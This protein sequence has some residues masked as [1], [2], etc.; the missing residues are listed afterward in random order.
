MLKL[1]AS[2]T[3]P[4]LL[5]SQFT[6]KLHSTPLVGGRMLQETGHGSGGDFTPE[7]NPRTPTLCNQGVRII[8]RGGAKCDVLKW[9]LEEKVETPFQMQMGAEMAYPASIFHK[10]MFGFTNRN[11]DRIIKQTLLKETR[12]GQKLFPLR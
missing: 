4:W 8:A 9:T 2:P 11:D 7:Q 10:I 6:R 5:P 1:S 12:L 3:R